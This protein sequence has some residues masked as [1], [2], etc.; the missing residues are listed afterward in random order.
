MPDYCLLSLEDSDSDEA[1]G[2][3]AQPVSATPSGNEDVRINAWLGPG[4]TLSPLHYDRYHSVCTTRSPIPVSLPPRRAYCVWPHLRPCADLLCQVVGSKYV[5]LYAPEHAHRLY[6]HAA[7]PHVVSSQIIDP[8]SVDRAKF[9]LFATAT[10]IDHILREGEALYIPP[11]WWH[12]IESRE[13]SFSVSFWW[14]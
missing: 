10:Y 14:S 12:F 9:P 13:T 5:R 2:G 4:G 11:G 7:G 6:A 3:L 1:D 8:D